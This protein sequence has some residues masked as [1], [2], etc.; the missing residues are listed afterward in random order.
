LLKEV[1]PHHPAWQELIEESY[2]LI[3]HRP[4]IDFALV[5]LRRHLNLPVGAAFGLF[6]LGRSVGWIAHALEQRKSREL[7][8][9]RAAYAGHP[10]R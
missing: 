6:A 1:L 7:I 4:T 5:A 2:A 3:G 9:P 8:R 10:R